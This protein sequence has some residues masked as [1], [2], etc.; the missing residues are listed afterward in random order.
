MASTLQGK[1]IAIL[2]ADGM[3]RVELAQSPDAVQPEGGHADL[4]SLKSG[5]IQAMTRNT[6]A[7]GT[8]TVVSGSNACGTPS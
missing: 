6:E 4:R 1:N 7:A 2:D 8:F 5:D 3:E